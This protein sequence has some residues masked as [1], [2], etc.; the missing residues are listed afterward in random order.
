MYPID[1]I[2]PF[3]VNDEKWKRCNFLDIYK[4]Y[5]NYYSFWY[6]LKCGVFQWLNNCDSSNF[7]FGY[8]FLESKE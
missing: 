2:Y 7:V 4:A 1:V 3:D 5:C 6:I 8:E